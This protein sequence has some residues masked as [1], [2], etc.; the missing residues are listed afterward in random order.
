LRTSEGSPKMTY[1]ARLSFT[2][3]S[4]K[5]DTNTYQLGKSF[6]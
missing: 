1:Y 6:G 4:I 5:I 3:V 2:V